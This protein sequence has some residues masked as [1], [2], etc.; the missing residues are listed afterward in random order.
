MF[1][2]V[3]LIDVGMAHLVAVL[4]AAV[5][6]AVTLPCLAILWNR[7][8]PKLWVLE[9]FLL[10]PVVSTQVVAVGIF[11]VPLWRH[12]GSSFAWKLCL[13][14]RFKGVCRW[15]ICLFIYILS[16]SSGDCGYHAGLRQGL[17]RSRLRRPS[18]VRA[19]QM[20]SC[21]CLGGVCR[22]WGVV[23]QMVLEV[24]GGSVFDHSCARHAALIPL[25]P[26][27]PSSSFPFQRPPPP[28]PRE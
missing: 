2:A 27:S 15:F 13:D 3:V 25:Y 7:G 4:A 22:R 20:C 24:W 28:P 26:S 16:L 12:N 10:M 23:R 18:C 17:G 9:I 6:L 8:R 19:P 5:M 21:G 14:V 1:R 11:A